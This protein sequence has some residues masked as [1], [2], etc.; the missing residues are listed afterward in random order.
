MIGA[1]LQL[2]GVVCAVVGGTWAVGPWFLLAAG[3]VL[4][5]VP[6]LAEPRRREP[7]PG[8]VGLAPGPAD[9]PERL[10]PRRRERRA[11]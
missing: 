2:F 7:A 8:P 3:V 10:R 1:V 11:S 6:E 4:L 9:V 5:V